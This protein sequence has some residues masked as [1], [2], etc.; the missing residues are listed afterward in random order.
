LH[1]T[2]KDDAP[3][4]RDDDRYGRGRGID[5][6]HQDYDDRQRPKGDRDR[7][8]EGG[9]RGRFDRRD[10][11]DDSPRR[12]RDHPDEDQF[13]RRPRS[14]SR[15]GN[16]DDRYED[17]YD[18]PDD[19]E[20]DDPHDDHDD[21]QR[22][23]SR[24]RRGRSPDRSRSRPPPPEMEERKWPPSF[25]KDG[26]AFVFDNRSAMFYEAKSDFFYDPKSKL[27]YSNKKESYFRYDEKE[28]PPFVMVE[29]EGNPLEASEVTAEL[30]ASTISKPKPMI[31]IK[32]KSVKKS[33]GSKSA[34]SQA[35][36]QSSAVSKETKQRIAN[37]EKWI[38]K[39]AEMKAES[40]PER[41]D[42]SRLKIRWTKKG[43]PIC[44]ICKRK[45]QSVEKL[46]LHERESELHKQ[47]LAN[48]ENARESSFKRKES[49]AGTYTDRAQK[50]RDLHGI[51]EA[52]ALGTSARINEPDEPIESAAAPNDTLGSDN[53][54][55]QLL[56]KMGWK[57]SEKSAA[58]P[59]DNLRKDWDRIENLA[60]SN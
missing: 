24:S 2:F 10:G 41:G 22:H 18:D 17:R 56:R 48:L 34:N 51:E 13:G 45:F 31:A 53:I 57:E 32:L 9:R 14:H 36:Q 26:S 35:K 47:N 12:S 39:Q 21:D 43:Q 6:S 27:Y 3:R 29:K 33:K 16:Y 49:P 42:E 44:I 50:R 28:D 4:K 23:R 55:N 59:Q 37:M 58:D 11:F 30:I 20:Y 54:G 46:R 19:N 60:K 7:H 52:A 25:D 8:L 15:G 1:I 38:K 5:S 40:C